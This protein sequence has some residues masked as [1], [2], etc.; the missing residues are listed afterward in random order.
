MLRT[1][2]ATWTVALV[3]STVAACADHES[4]CAS[5]GG[6]VATRPCCTSTADFPNTCA[7]GACGCSPDTSAPRHV[8]QCPA[9]Q[10]F[11]GTACVTRRP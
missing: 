5:A 1:R 11:N 9:G 10:C 7:L 3:C 6:T 2:L 4:A 8:C